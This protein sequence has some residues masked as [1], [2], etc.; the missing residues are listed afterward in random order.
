MNTIIKFLKDNDIEHDSTEQLNTSVKD[1]ENLNQLFKHQNTAQSSHLKLRPKIRQNQIW[2]VKSE[3]PDFLGNIQKTAHPFLVLTNTE[4]DEAYEEEF[5][6]VLTISPFVEMASEHDRICQDPSITGFPFLIETWNEQP[7]LTE[8]LDE[9]I[10][11][12]E[13]KQPLAI[14]EIL[15]SVQKE[16]RETEISRAKYLNHSVSA[17][18]AF[19]SK[20]EN[21]EFSATILFSGKT[22]F[23][24]CPKERLSANFVVSEPEV[25]YL[26]VSKSGMAQKD[27]YIPYHS[28]TLPFDIYIG[29]NDAGFVLTVFTANDI[30]LF[31]VNS[32]KITGLSNREQTVFSSLEKGLYT[33]YSKQIQKTVQIRLK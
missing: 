29:K 7:V 20:N 32:K 19:M 9:Y 16:F 1:I 31:D 28:E 4:S 11:Y 23:L 13:A 17:L 30:E 15:T 27:K 24:Y 3:Y 6:R 12:Y 22:Q 33:I 21:Q 8:I 14:Q 5:V 2:S 10:G 26:S 25:E 18:L